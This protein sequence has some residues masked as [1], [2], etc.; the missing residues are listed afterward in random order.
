M[1]T[2][3]SFLILLTISVCSCKKDKDNVREIFYSSDQVPNSTGDYWKYNVKSLTGE[4]I[5]YLEVRIIKKVVLPDGRQVTTWIYSYPSFTDTVYKVL[6]DT[7]LEEFS[8]FPV[9]KGDNYPDMLYKFPMVPGMKWAINRTL[10]SDSVRVASDTVVT[11]PVGTFEHSMRLDFIST[12]VI[13]N[14][15]NSSRFWVT[16]HVGNTRMEY[17]VYNLGPDRHNGIYELVDFELRH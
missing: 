17:K 3:I 5:G 11:V 1:K 10:V 2:I 12:H 16:P 6:S 14:Y 7:T 8:E 15:L 9:L 13:I 4:Q